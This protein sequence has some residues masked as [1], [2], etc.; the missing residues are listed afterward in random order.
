MKNIKFS[1]L[2][3]NYIEKVNK[4]CLLIMCDEWYE[5][6][7]HRIQAERSVVSEL[8]V[9]EPWLWKEHNPPFFQNKL[10]KHKFV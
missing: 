5:S 8:R 4:N 1:F 10:E 3:E 9:V 7:N 2:F 6:Q